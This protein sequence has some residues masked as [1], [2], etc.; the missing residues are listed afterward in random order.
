[1]PKT[2]EQKQEIISQL[3][4]KLEKQ[5]SAVLVDFAGIPAK[6]LFDLRDNLKEQGCELYV[7]KKTLLKKALDQIKTKWSVPSKAEGIIGKLDEIKGQLALVLGF[8]D[9]VAPAKVCFD[10]NKQDENLKILGGILNQNFVEKEYII[11]LARL[12]SRPEL[13]GRLAGSLKAPISNLAYVLQG[14]IK[15]LVFVLNGIKQ[16]KTQ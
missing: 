8:G 14:N 15:G 9:E 11:S 2:K 16:N 6:S 7:S 13:L 12:P 4:D 3:N 5:K 10:F 1:M